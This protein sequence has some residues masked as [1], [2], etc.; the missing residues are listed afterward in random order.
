VYEYTWDYE[1]SVATDPGPDEPDDP[2]E[3]VEQSTSGK[4]IWVDSWRVPRSNAAG[5]SALWDILDPPMLDDEGQW[6][7]PKATGIGTDDIGGMAISSGGEPTSYGVFQR[8][9]S[10]THF[11]APIPDFATL[12]SITNKRNNAPFAGYAT[13]KVVYVGDNS[14]RVAEELWQV[15]HE[16]VV[17]EW[18][19]ARQAAWRDPR[20]G[21]PVLAVSGKYNKYAYPVYWI[22]PYPDVANFDD[23]NI[24]SGSSGGDLGDRP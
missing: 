13:G 20:D 4:T 6:K 16:F 3:F 22:Q 23:L 21:I 14:T 15:I 1:Y 18:F 17:D 19:H 10:V 9:I 2:L 8:V 12:N 7:Q 11:V 5:Q 24:P